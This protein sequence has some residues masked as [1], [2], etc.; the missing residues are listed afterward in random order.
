LGVSSVIA[1]CLLTSFFAL[2]IPFGSLSTIEG[3]IFCTP[4][5]C[6]WITWG[7]GILAGILGII[8]ALLGLW[9]NSI[10]GKNSDVESALANGFALS[11]YILGGLQGLLVPAMI[12]LFLLGAGSIAGVLLVIFLVSLVGQLLILVGTFTVSPSGNEDETASEKG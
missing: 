5:T 4:P 10:K 1:A 2:W 12:I 9:R 8:G 7:V 3:P 6:S 11:R